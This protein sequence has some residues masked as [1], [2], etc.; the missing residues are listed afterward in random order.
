MMAFHRGRLTVAAL[1]LTLAGAV[2]G[3]GHVL[4]LGP[5]TSPAPGPL[6]VPIVLRLALSQ[7]SLSLGGC[8]AGYTLFT[9]PAA[10]TTGSLPPGPCYRMTGTPVTFT[11]AAVELYLQPE[12]SQPVQHPA[13][14]GLSVT[15][16][17]TEAAALAAITTRSQGSGNPVTISIAGTTWALVMTAAP[18]TNGR[19]VFMTQSK[20]QALQLQRTLVPGD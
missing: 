12:G 6:S 14:W 4:P 3:C 20:N 1:A 7:P 13:T 8:P 16:P 19:F 15:V 11:S 17:G 18:L 9:A 5:D 10:D 2:A